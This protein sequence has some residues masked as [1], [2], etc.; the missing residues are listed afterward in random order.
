MV[1]LIHNEQVGAHGQDSARKLVPVED[2]IIMEH[3][4]TA[5]RL[6]MEGLSRGDTDKCGG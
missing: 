6:T 5:T 2:L 3:T 1:C 4:V